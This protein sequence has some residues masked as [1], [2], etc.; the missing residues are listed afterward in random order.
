MLY[1]I[2]AEVSGREHNFGVFNTTKDEALKIADKI[3]SKLVFARVKV[4]R[5]RSLFE[6]WQWYITVAR[7]EPVIYRK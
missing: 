6:D 3:L 1:H 2:V 5:R 7:A 4:D